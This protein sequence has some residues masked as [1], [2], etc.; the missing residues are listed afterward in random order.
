MSPQFLFFT[1][2]DARVAGLIFL[3]QQI[4][5]GPLIFISRSISKAFFGHVSNLNRNSS[6][7]LLKII[8]ITVIRLLIIGIIPISFLAWLGPSIFGLIFGDQWVESG[9]FA[10]YLSI[11]LL[12]QFSIA[13]IFQTLIVVEKLITL[14]VIDVFRLLVVI[15]AILII[16]EKNYG[17]DYVV[18]G[19]SLSLSIAYVFG[20][21]LVR[22]SI[23]INDS[24]YKNET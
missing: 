23:K 5:A 24:M 8:D 12:A 9:T 19:Y 2:Y 17:I 14:A 22:K 6:E 13:P 4:V 21:I 16:H 20:Y 11:Y 18:I 1:L 7:S 15:A 3:A 10:R